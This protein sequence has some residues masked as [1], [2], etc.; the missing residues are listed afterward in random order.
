M[1]VHASDPSSSGGILSWVKPPYADELRALPGA[2]AAALRA[3]VW[4][5]RDALT[6]LGRGPAAFAGSGG[7]MVL[8][9]LAARLHEWTFRQPA[10]ACS[11]L[12][13]VDLPQLAE[14]GALLFSSSGK[15]PDAQRVL[16]DFRRSRFRP[17]VVVTHRDPGGLQERAGADTSIVQLPALDQP[18]GFLATGSVLQMTVALLRGYLDDPLLPASA[19]GSTDEETDLRGEV[20]VLTSPALAAVAAD[21]EVRLVESGLA[22]VQVADYRNFAHGRHTGFARRLAEVTVIA[23]SDPA[24][25]DLASGTTAALPGNA[26]VRRWHHDG[27]WPEAVVGLLMRSMRLAGKEG[28]RVGLDVGRPAV[29]AFGRRLYRLPLG[30]RLPEHLAGGVERK[31]LALGAGDSDELRGM[32]RTAHERWE[33]QLGA[34]R[35]RGVVLDYDG[36]AC[37]TSRR[38]TLPDAPVRAGL[39]RLLQHGALLGFASGR[40]QSLHRD[41][42]SWLPRPL[43]GHVVVG[44]YNGAVQ[45]R[46]DDPLPDLRVPTAWSGAVVATLAALP[47]I[48]RLQIEERGAQVTVEVVRG[49]VHHGYLPQVVREQ[50]ASAEVDA[51]VVVSGHSIDVIRPET[52]KTAVLDAL[53]ELCGGAVL[54]VGDQGQIGGNDHALL[55]HTSFSVTVDRCSADPTR[56][57]YIGDGQQNGPDLLA[58][59]LRALRPLKAGLALTMKAT[60]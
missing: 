51:Q 54:V 1:P 55:A 44:L 8:A 46:L 48:D 33:E 29:P 24:S 56:C 4:S 15:H 59:H 2:Y 52:C 47:L 5:L 30:R 39:L 32:Y 27:P 42:R 40:G 16:G 19:P 43:W 9:I 38:R 11:A 6:D 18:D 26:D 23:L 7:T 49:T 57:W 53:R 31:L 10:R 14:R 34:E 37:F 13:L 60:P 3:D 45:V 35:F 12:E 36:T 17:A 25:N 50:L 22:A 58:R 41:L 28:E 20:L 21:L